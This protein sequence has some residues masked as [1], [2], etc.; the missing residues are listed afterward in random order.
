MIVDLVRA[1]KRV[2]IT[3]VSH[4]VIRNLLDEVVRA[5]ADENTRIS[6]MH[7]VSSKSM[8][9]GM[10]V[11]DETDAAN[12]VVSI[13][14]GDFDVVGGTAWVWSKQDLAGADPIRTVLAEGLARGT[15]E[16]ITV[17]HELVGFL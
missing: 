4:K 12:A 14:N 2:G 10:G 11:H 5:A 9:D 3:A 8:M 13:M 16:T 6:C 1:G 7:R 15:Q 17:V